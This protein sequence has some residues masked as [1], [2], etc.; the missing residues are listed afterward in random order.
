MRHSRLPARGRGFEPRPRDPK[1]LVLPLDDPR[2]PVALL[3]KTNYNTGLCHK[4]IG[5]GA[6]AYPRFLAGLRRAGLKSR[7]WASR[8]PS[9]ACLR[10]RV[11]PVH[12][13]ASFQFTAA[14][15]SD[16]PHRPE[17]PVLDVQIPAPPVHGG[18]P[19]R[20]TAAH[21]S[22]MPHRPEAP[23]LDDQI[24]APP[25]YGG[26]SFQFAAVRLSCSR[27]RTF[28]ICHAGLKRRRWMSTAPSTACSRRCVFPVH[29]GASFRFTAVRLSSSRRRV[30]PVHGGA[31]SQGS[32]SCP[33]AMFLS[34][35][36]WDTSGASGMQGLSPFLSNLLQPRQM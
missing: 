1:S 14:H 3:Y 30:F 23:V 8:K 10:R 25:V 24:P 7:C 18:A 19:F 9:T 29:G 2:L 34:K 27:R 33:A 5:D 13:S 15:L 16:T 31:T 36:T 20:F 12:G 4:R 11:F 17:A 35:K 6:R 28:R 26:A 21:L 22:D 32:A